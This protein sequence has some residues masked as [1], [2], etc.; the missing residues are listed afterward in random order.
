MSAIGAEQISVPSALQ[1]ELMARRDHFG[2]LE[3]GQRVG[4][5]SPGRRAEDEHRA[6]ESRYLPHRPLRNG[7]VACLGRPIALIS[8]S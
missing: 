4:V 5:K 6:G 3:I 2:V 1:E 8:R 7:G